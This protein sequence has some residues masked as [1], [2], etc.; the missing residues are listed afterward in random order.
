[1]VKFTKKEQRVKNVSSTS[2]ILGAIVKNFQKL[3]RNLDT[4]NRLELS[5]ILNCYRYEAE[6]VNFDFNPEKWRRHYNKIINDLTDQELNSYFAEIKTLI[7]KCDHLIHDFLLDNS[8]DFKHDL[9]ELIALYSRTYRYAE[10]SNTE[11]YSDDFDY[12]IDTRENIHILFELLSAS[13]SNLENEI[14][15]IDQKMLDLIK[16]N[17]LDHELFF[18]FI[19][20]KNHWWWHLHEIDKLSKKDLETI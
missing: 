9:D 1:M 7:E 2:D 10:K 4:S 11:L 20:P 16:R 13:R 14:R 12:L 8:R 6:F 17:P 5:E 18:S 15:E 19:Y 3:I